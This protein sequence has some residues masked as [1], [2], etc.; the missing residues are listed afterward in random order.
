MVIIINVVFCE[1]EIHFSFMKDQ[2]MHVNKVTCMYS[3]SIFIKNSMNVFVSTFG[4]FQLELGFITKQDKF[5]WETRIDKKRG[6]KQDIK[7]ASIA[8]FLHH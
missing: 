3:I 1:L 5:S 6:S 4:E 2:L 7:S 8:V